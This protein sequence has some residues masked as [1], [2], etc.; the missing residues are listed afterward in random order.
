MQP[1]NPARAGFYPAP[2]LLD[3]YEVHP[4]TPLAIELT[5]HFLN[6]LS[7]SHNHIITTDLYNF[8]IFSDLN[9][10]V[11]LPQSSTAGD[12]TA[13]PH[14]PGSASFGLVPR[15]PEPYLLKCNRFGVWM[16][17]SSCSI[18]FKLRHQTTANRQVL[19]FVAQ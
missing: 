3:H 9:K 14:F 18:A 4:P 13:S 12:F 15:L 11:P 7:P 19:A 5:H 10:L 2:G 17:G 8:Q 16:I 1:L 6:H